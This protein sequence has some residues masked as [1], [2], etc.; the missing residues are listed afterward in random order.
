MLK[1]LLLQKIIIQFCGSG[2]H[3]HSYSFNGPALLLAEDADGLLQCI[4][5][6]LNIGHLLLTVP[7]LLL[8]M[9]TLQQR[10][11]IHVNGFPK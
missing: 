4:L 6:L 2:L 9:R 3:T 7:I 11:T 1:D 10:Y 8:N 5:T